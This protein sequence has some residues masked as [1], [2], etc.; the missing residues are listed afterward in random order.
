MVGVVAPTDQTRWKWPTVKQ[1]QAAVLNASSYKV[2][3][4]LPKKQSSLNHK[5]TSAR[6]GYQSCVTSTS[7]HDDGWLLVALTTYIS[8]CLD[9]L[10]DI[11]GVERIFLPGF[12]GMSNHQHPAERSVSND[13]MITYG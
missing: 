6:M 5:E 10:H 9:A 3:S 12:Y 11:R 1:R 13:R 8:L 2:T 7:T 4:E